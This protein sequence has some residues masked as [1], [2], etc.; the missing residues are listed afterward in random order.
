M[1]NRIDLI[2]VAKGMSILLVAFHHSQLASRYSEVSSAMGLFRMP[3]FFFLSGVF[4]KAVAPPAEFFARK[5]EALLKPYFVTLGL[6]L[7]TSILLGRDHILDE[8]LGILYGIG[9]TIRWTPMW[10]LTMLWTLFMGSYVLVRWLKLDT[11]S[12]ALKSMMLLLMLMF[13]V[14]WMALFHGAEFSLLGQSYTLSG[15]PFSVDLVFISMAYFLAGHFLSRNVREFE[16]NPWLLSGMLVVFFSIVAFTDAAIDLNR[17][18]YKEPVLATFGAVSGIYLVLT[19]SYLFSR[20]SPIKSFFKAFG[21]A[22]LF[23][24]IFHYVLMAKLQTGFNLWLSADWLLVTGAIS[25]AFSVTFPL[26][27]KVIVERNRFLRP[28][29]FPIKRAQ[30]GETARSETVPAD[31]SLTG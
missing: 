23:I 24:L 27:I 10:F 21:S 6:L 3:L 12:A 15:L 22:S 31:K 7:L 28:L 17:R 30:P 29:Y 25:Y 11:R 2:D 26:F 13:G 18:L 16:P 19:I 14:Y 4:F 1:R 5:T 20:V 9:D 8:A